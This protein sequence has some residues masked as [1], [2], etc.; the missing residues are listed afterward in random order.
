[1]DSNKCKKLK[2]RTDLKKY[3]KPRNQFYVFK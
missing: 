3:K 2:A 1:M